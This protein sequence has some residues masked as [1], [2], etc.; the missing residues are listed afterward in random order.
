MTDRDASE[1]EI[2]YQ[3]EGPVADAVRP[4]A[5]RMVADIG[6]KAPRPVIFARVK[7]KI[8]EDRV[9]DEQAIAQVTMDVSGSIIRA[10][11]AAPTVTQ[12]LTTLEHRLDRQLRRLAEKRET[13]TERPPSTPSGS[14]RHGDLPDNRPS[15]FPRPPEERQILRRKSFAPDEMSVEEALFDLDVLDHRFFL[16]VDQADGEVSVV[17]EEDGAVVM[18]RSSGTDPADRDRPVPV[19]VNPTEA[20]TLSVEEAVERLEVSGAP[21]VFFKER[22]TD[23]SKALYLRYDGHYGLIEPPD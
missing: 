4:E 23:Q 11:V 19:E 21:F 12:A 14:W 22:G 18:R 1:I 9:N 5:E 8:N 6:A 2:V 16:F 17:Y 10:Q 3:A 15:F 7:V 20:P 13:A